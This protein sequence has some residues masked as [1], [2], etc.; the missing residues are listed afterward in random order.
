MEW[1]TLVEQHKQGWG[2]QSDHL[3]DCRFSMS[4]AGCGRQS[5]AHTSIGRDQGTPLSL[6]F[7]LLFQLCF[8]RVVES[9]GRS[10]RGRLRCS[11]FCSSA[12]S[13]YLIHKL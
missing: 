12:P 1:T 2:L 3:F 8:A 10:V 13:S 9:L 4:S 11:C 5:E 7:A 6:R